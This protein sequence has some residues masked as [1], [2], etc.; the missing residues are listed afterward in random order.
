MRRP[1]L[2]FLAL[3]ACGFAARADTLIPGVAAATYRP[4]YPLLVRNPLNALVRVEVNIGKINASDIFER[5]DVRLTSLAFRLDGSDVLADVSSLTLY[6]TGPDERLTPIRW[7][8]NRGGPVQRESVGGPVPPAATLTFHLDQLLPGGRNVFW[9]SARLRDSADLSHW[10][11]VTCTGIATTAGNLHPPDGSPDVRQRLGLA[12]RRHGDDGV[13]TYGIPSVTTSPRG[14][15]LCVYDM[16]RRF[17]GHDLQ[18]DIDI[19]LSRS[20]DGGRT[21]EPVRVIMDMGEYGGLPEEQ[22][23]CSDP[24][25]IVDRETGRV[26]CFACWMNGMPGHH[27]WKTNGAAPGYEIGQTPQFMAVHSLDDGRTWSKPENL[28]RQ[29]K[30]K[31]WWLLTTSPQHGIQIADGTLVMP[32]EGRGPTGHRFA[33]IMTSRDH[34]EHWAVGTPTA[35]GCSECD[36]VELGDGS[37]M[38]NARHTEI[39][40]GEALRRLVYVTRDLGRTWQEHPTSHLALIEPICNAAMQR[41]D[42]EEGGAKRHVLL[43]ANPHSAVERIRVNQTIQV[44]FDDGMTWPEDHHLL[45][46]EGLGWGYPSMTQ[47]DAQHIG[48]VYGSSQTDIAFQIISTAELLRGK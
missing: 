30:Q 28:T 38:L 18:D 10:L 42:Y 36:I 27:Q 12:L 1:I 25:I 17:P 24:G 35:H 22:N 40:P 46:D 33:T 44:S 37:L 5:N 9:L 20:A 31:E 32:I 2:S 29:L 11:K 43:F 4:V 3:V 8:P 23:G 16:R 39:V 48:I 34:G 47:A 41:V 45:L 26:T 21:W 14:T 13:D 19:G 7:G 15:L 6:S